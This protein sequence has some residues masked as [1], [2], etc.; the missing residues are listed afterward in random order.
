MQCS[1]K[2]YYC[3]NKCTVSAGGDEHCSSWLPELTT[4]GTGGLRTHCRAEAVV[5]ELTE[6]GRRSAGGQRGLERAGVLVGALQKVWSS[7]RPFDAAKLHS[8]D[9]R[10]LLTSVRS[11]GGH[12][13]GVPLAGAS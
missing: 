1:Q 12:R 7:V 4:V 9:R 3:K 11:S 2:L 10:S 13:D 5:L 6:A 8:E